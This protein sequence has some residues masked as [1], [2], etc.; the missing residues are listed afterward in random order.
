MLIKYIMEI[1]SKLPNLKTTIFTIMG[2]MAKDYDAINL[3]QGFPDFEM[4]GELV[5]LV[6][7]GMKSG[8]NQYAPMQ[9]VFSLREEITKKY[10]KLYGAVYHPATEITLTAGATQA[11]FTAILA[12]IH[13][14]DEVIVFK[15]AYDCYEPA[16]KLAG[17]KPICIQLESPEYKVDWQEV[18]K[19]ITEK[20]KMILINTPHNPSGIVWTKNDIDSLATLVEQT[21]I[22]VLSDEVY[23]HIVFD[24]VPHLSVCANKVLRERSFITASFGKTFHNTGWKMGYCAAPESLMKEFQKV[25]QYNVFSVNHPIQVALAEY[26]K[27]EAHYLSLPQLFQRKRDLFLRELAGSKFK[28]LPSKGTYFQLLDYSNI[29]DENDVDFAERLVKEHGVASI[30][31]SVFNKDEHDQKMLRFCFAKKDETLKKAAEILNAIR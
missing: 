2:K 5:D 9:G 6:T 29:T 23:E 7:Q 15:P 17:G 27:N 10:E 25:H 4:D 14:N 3:S 20:T 22:L 18:K 11:I 13:K 31:I 1:T 24:Q 28:F 16:I 8:Y 30:P 26:L 12:I 19:S 21:D